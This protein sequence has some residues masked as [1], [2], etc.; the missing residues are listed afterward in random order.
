M[1]T[2]KEIGEIFLARRAEIDA[3]D[4]ALARERRK[5]QN[6]AIDQGRLMNEEDITRRKEIGSTRQELAE[7]SEILALSTLDKLK[8][9]DDIEAL[10]AELLQVNEMLKDDL[11]HLE[12]IEGYGENVAK[13]AAGLTSAAAKVVGVVL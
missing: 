3:L 13:V 10:N 11:A 6:D 4:Q 8:T 12:T 1:A 7:A 2:I 5:I 9:N